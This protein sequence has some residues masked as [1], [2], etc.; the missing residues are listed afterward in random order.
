[1]TKQFTL[2]DLYLGWSIALVTG[3]MRRDGVGSYLFC[4]NGVLVR[5][6]TWGKHTHFMSLKDKKCWLHTPSLNKVRMYTVEKGI[7]R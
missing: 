5:I 2:Q 6:R 3:E 1:M 4:V 7:A